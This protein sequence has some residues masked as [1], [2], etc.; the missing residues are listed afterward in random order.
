MKRGGIIF[1]SLLFL[2]IFL[3]LISA[4]QLQVTSE[5]P[6]LV[7]NEWIPASD[8]NV[9]DNL[10]TA[11][12]KT[13][14]I[15][16]IEFVPDKAEVYN[17]ESSLYH[18]FVLGDG[19]IVHNSNLASK[20]E[21]ENALNRLADS[22]PSAIDITSGANK[23]VYIINIGK[24][25]NL[26]KFNELPQGIRQVL[27]E[28]NADNSLIVIKLVKRQPD[29]MGSS[30]DFG[31]Q[32]EAASLKK[33]EKASAEIKSEIGTEPRVSPRLIKYE[34]SKDLEFI[35]EE[36]VSGK[37]LRDIGKLYKGYELDSRAKEL[38]KRTFEKTFDWM[39]S[40]DYVFKRAEIC[41]ID[42]TNPNNMM[43]NYMYK[44]KS[45]TFEQ[46]VKNNIPLDCLDMDIRFVDFDTAI[47]TKPGM[48]YEKPGIRDWSRISPAE[49]KK[50]L[51]N[52]FSDATLP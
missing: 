46:L 25:K 1:F 49:Q 50:R 11:D 48:I 28:S 52:I 10:K 9:G 33:I 6:F 43:I 27:A 39:N 7:N 13:A 35:A 32:N 4:S 36:G 2:I 40:A 30:F 38:W 23:Q 34:S 29:A 20:I 14:R 3:P 5:H 47:Q 12:G 15:T 37:T 16:G 44:G 51:G 26:N 42:Y 17:L 22:A 19:L 24:L 41:Y 45:Y 18:N 31:L 8:L 21:F